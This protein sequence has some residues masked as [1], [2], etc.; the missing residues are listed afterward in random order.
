MY[1]SV[2]VKYRSSSA[3]YRLPVS[4]RPKSAYQER[5]SPHKAAAATNTGGGAPTRHNE[6]EF[7]KC[8]VVTQDKIWKQRVAT[9][10]RGVKAWLVYSII[11]MNLKAKFLKILL[12]YIHDINLY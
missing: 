3:G 10:S 12:N 5:P 2:T 8:D 4:S 6:A 1:S 9:E 11:R 7:A